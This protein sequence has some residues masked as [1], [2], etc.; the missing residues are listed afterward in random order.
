V[1]LRRTNITLASFWVAASRPTA[2]NSICGIKRHIAAQ[3]YG[4]I[5]IIADEKRN[6]AYFQM[7]I[8]LTG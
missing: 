6:S 8:F 5:K 1:R 7:I 2:N 4:R 3:K